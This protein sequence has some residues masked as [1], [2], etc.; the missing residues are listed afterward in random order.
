MPQNM[1]SPSGLEFLRT[2]EERFASLHDW[3]FEPRYVTIGEGLRVHYVDEG[4]GPTVLL[5]HG[6]PTWG[7]LY[8]KMIPAL[9]GSGCRV[10]VPDLVGFGRSDKPTSRDDYTYGR[11]LRWLTETIEAIEDAAPLGPITMF[12]QDWGGL[13]GLSHI[14]RYSQ[15][16]RGVVVSNTGVPLGRDIRMNDDDGFPTWRQFSQDV[17]PFLASV[18]VAG[19]S[20]PLNSTGF[21]LSDEEQRAYDAPFPEEAYAAGAR[22]FPLLVPTSSVHPSAPICRETWQLLA[23]CQVP[24]TTAFGSDDAVTGPLQG[25]MSSSVPGA[26]NQPHVII[27]NAGHFIQEHQPDQCVKAIVDL[28]DRTQ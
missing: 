19:S 4:V 20:S 11:H 10:V 9:V 1:T 25:L 14:A 5:L 28:L 2:P 3:S 23:T 24:L 17:S 8:R 26:A 16:Y 21:Q 12:C 13:L 15:T 18:C 7:Y 22:Q 6:E 27:E